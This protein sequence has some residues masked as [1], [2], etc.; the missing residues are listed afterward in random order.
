MGDEV[1]QGWTRK[2][3]VNA[4]DQLHQVFVKMQ[5]MLISYNRSLNWTDSLIFK[6]GMNFGRSRIWIA[7]GSDGDRVGLRSRCITFPFQK[8]N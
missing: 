5:N 8:F 6:Q 2:R 3:G 4:Q 1:G 7:I